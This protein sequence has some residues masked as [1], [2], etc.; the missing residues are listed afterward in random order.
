MNLLTSFVIK[1]RKALM[2]F[3][4]VAI[5]AAAVFIPFTK[6]NYDETDYLPEDSNTKAGLA[7]LEHEFG[8]GGSATAMLKSASP[9]DALVIKKQI[10]GVKGVAGVMWLDDA[11]AFDMSAP[12]TQRDDS[13]GGENGDG[14]LLFFKAIS[15][16][17]KGP[18]T[19][20]NKI[21]QSLGNVLTEEELSSAMALF[22]G[23][24]FPGIDLSDPESFEKPLGLSYGVFLSV[25]NNEIESF[26][27]DGNALFTIAFETGD[28]SSDTFDAIK[29]IS[30]ISENLILS[31]NSASSYY[32]KQNQVREIIYATLM[33]SAVALVLLF[34]FSSSWLDP[35][36]Y[37]AVILAAIA[38]N[39]GTNAIF[40]SVSYLTQS[41]AC[42]LQLALSIDYAVF[43][44]SRYK[45]ERAAGLDA[46]D[47]MKAALKRSFTPISASSL[48][49]IACF[50]TIMFMKY[51]LGF[52]MGII[53][54]KA[55][56]MSLVT[57]FFFM[58]GIVVALDGKIAKY[59]HKT[60]QFKPK[61]LSSFLYRYRVVLSVA[62]AVIIIPAAFLASDNSFIY[63]SKAAQS[64]DNTG[65]KNRAAIE[66]VFGSQEKLVLLVPKGEET[67]NGLTAS[68]KKTIGV[69]S[70][71]SLA[72][73]NQSP[74]GDYISENIKGGFIG[75]ENY[76]RIILT[77]EVPEEGN[78]TKALIDSIKSQLKLAYGEEENYYLL[79]NTASAIDLEDTTTSDFGRISLFSLIAV[80]IIVALAFR[81]VLVPVLLVAVIQGAIWINMSVPF[82]M[83]DKIIF[84]GYLIISNILL[85]STIDYA[86]LF[87]SNFFESRKKKPVK[88]SIYSALSASMRPILTSGVIFTIAG[89]V[90][91]LTSSFPTVRLLGYSIMRGGISAMIV[92]L[93]FLPALLAVTDK[94]II[95]KFFKRKN[96]SKVV[97]ESEE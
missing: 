4:A 30:L 38:L 50:I 73:I 77:L 74:L 82:L 70:V 1:R 84:L 97:K 88:E 29:E 54:A 40:G 16:L 85:G 86:I 3:F 44:L 6:I 52:D 20:L 7:V 43:L 69:G 13:S 62:A 90:L 60:L 8:R 79:G 32:A 75:G 53:M 2:I 49:T 67:Q 96:K 89:L 45:K 12:E 35:V 65:L 24:G 46:P 68:L 23:A 26:Y 56:I 10:A 15:A 22:L 17:P 27:K 91:G 61:K 31:G 55:I 18:D 33:A 41:V 59:E 71:A 47:A 83:G 80:G 78:E 58:P 51:K 11:F 5:L 28:Y 92:T 25:I 36:I 9:E 21:L 66:E 93:F 14:I 64:P 94:L 42:V 81:S 39:M 48:T 63:G 72:Q 57:V 37:I 19:T 76:D 95:F 34:I 87:T